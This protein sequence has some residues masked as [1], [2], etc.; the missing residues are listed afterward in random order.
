MN[1]SSDPDPKLDLKAAASGRTPWYQDI[2]VIGI[3]LVLFGLLVLPLV[4]FNKAFTVQKKIVITVIS[5]IIAA[6]LLY[7]GNLL[8][9]ELEQRQEAA[10]LTR[11]NIFASSG[12]AA[13]A[14]PAN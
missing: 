9:G 4:W 8:L 2:R 10:Q 5:V 14:G 7:V 11:S 6:I 13:T 3:L 1:P 12:P